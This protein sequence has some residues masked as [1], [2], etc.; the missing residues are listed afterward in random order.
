[1]TIKKLLKSMARAVCLVLTAPLWGPARFAAALGD[2]ERVFKACAELLSLFPG[3]PGVYLRQAYYR[4]TLAGCAADCHIGFGTI[5][6]HRNLFLEEGVYIGNRCTVGMARIG[7]DTT[8]GCNVDILSGRHQHFTHWVDVPVQQQGGEYVP[9]R[10]GNN[11]WVGNSAVVMADV[12]DNSVVGAGSVVVH[13]VPAGCM[14]A[15]NPAVVKK[16]TFAERSLAA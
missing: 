4:M 12:A 8:I 11:A 9:V 13:E 2:A 7:R 15:G 14:A 6:T 16:R 10:I 5:I 1:M 3:A